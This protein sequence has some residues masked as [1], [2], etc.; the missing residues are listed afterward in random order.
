[1]IGRNPT[2]EYMENI[3]RKSLTDELNKVRDDILSEANDKFNVAAQKV[4]DE[5]IYNMVRQFSVTTRDDPRM[6]RQELVIVLPDSMINK[7]ESDE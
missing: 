7:E 5:R 2:D 6:G 3:L 4:I 1:M